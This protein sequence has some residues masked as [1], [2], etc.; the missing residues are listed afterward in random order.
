MRLILAVFSLI[1]AG[2]IS[3]GSGVKDYED[4][5]PFDESD[6]SAAVQANLVIAEHSGTSLYTY[7]G[8]GLFV[9]GAVSFAFFNRSAGIQL[10]IAGAA[11]GSVPFIVQSE[12]FAWI[13]GG[14]LIAVAG[15]G[16]WHLWFKLKQA[17]AEPDDRQEK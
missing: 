10:I 17:E 1:L 14:T 8:V 6:I 5:L 4:Y 9:L 7:A 12:Y 15:M 11:A 16:I 3:A 2:C 13:T